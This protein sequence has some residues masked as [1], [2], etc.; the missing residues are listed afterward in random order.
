MERLG[1][2]LLPH[3]SDAL[4]KALRRDMVSERNKALQD[5]RWKDY[6]L[7]NVRLTVRILEAFGYRI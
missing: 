3:E 6:H 4:I 5:P 2:Y 7:R 1:D